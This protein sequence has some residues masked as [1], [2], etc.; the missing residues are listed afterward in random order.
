MGKNKLSIYM[1]KEGV[2]E[3]DII[4]KYENYGFVNDYKKREIDHNKTIYFNI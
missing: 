2:D 3:K 1:I 4:K